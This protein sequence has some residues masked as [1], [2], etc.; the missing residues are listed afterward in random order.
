MRN[1]LALLLACTTLSARADI[2]YDWVGNNDAAPYNISLKLVFTDD[3]FADGGVDFNVIGGWY[4]PRLTD[5]G[6][7]SLLYVAPGPMLPVSFQPSQVPMGFYH[8]LRMHL[9]VNET[10]A[11]SGNFYANN[12]ESH[13]MMDGEDGLFRVTSSNSDRSMIW[14]GCPD[15]SKDCNGAT[16]RFVRQE[17]GGQQLPE[18][19][20]LGL[21]AL[22]LLGMCYSRRR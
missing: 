3:A 5:P 17:D 7:V 9:T 13:I 1:L 14:A 16:G 12:D 20:T 21:T 6:L 18:P 10:G 15:T 8:S 11:L 19:M 4:S 22:G 2:I